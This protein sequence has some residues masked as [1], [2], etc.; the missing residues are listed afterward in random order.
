MEKMKTEKCITD[1]DNKTKII[2]SLIKSGTSNK[3]KTDA[4]EILL[5]ESDF[6]K[7]FANIGQV[8]LNIHDFLKKLHIGNALCIKKH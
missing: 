6:N 2:W 7:Y 3:E 5:T 8:T 1:P 4:V